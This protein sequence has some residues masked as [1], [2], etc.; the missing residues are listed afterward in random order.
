MY[1]VVEC[2]T[3]VAPSAS[4]RCS[5]GEA[6]VLSTTTGMPRAAAQRRHRGDVDQLEHRVGGRLQPDQLGASA[7][8]RASTLL[9]RPHVD[10]GDLDAQRPHHGVEQAVGAAVDVVAAQDVVPRAQGVQQG[11]GRPAAAAEGEAQLAPLQRGQGRL[12]RRPG[13]VAAARVVEA[14]RLARLGLGEGAGQHDR[15]HHRAVDGVADAG[16]RGW[17]GS[18]SAEAL[19]SPCPPCRSCLSRITDRGRGGPSY[20]PDGQGKP[21]DVAGQSTTVRRGTAAGKASC[22]R[23]VVRKTGCDEERR[24]A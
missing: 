2:S 22:R 13:G 14:Q 9:D 10:E 23:V 19:P 6:K 12:Q 5:T 1:L 16:R 11:G 18:R 21:D 24:P 3:A 4:G 17:R 20:E 7:A 8:A 15:L